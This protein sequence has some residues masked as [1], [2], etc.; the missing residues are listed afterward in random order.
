V[1]HVKE[2]I[3]ERRNFKEKFNT[4]SGPAEINL[5]NLVNSELETARISWSNKINKLFLNKVIKFRGN[6]WNTKHSWENYVVTVKRVL[7]DNSGVPFNSEISIE[8]I[9]N[10]IYTILGSMNIK[11]YKDMDEYEIDQN[12]K[13]Y[14]L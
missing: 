8:D 12:S 3:L 13:K 1:K 14:N 11:I 9:N 10:N 7:S 2:L 6:K 5:E 4:N